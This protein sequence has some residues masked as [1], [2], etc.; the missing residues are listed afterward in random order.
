MH[1]L[2]VLAQL[3]AHTPFDRIEAHHLA[4]TRDF[5]ASH[6]DNFWRRNSADGHITASAF[7]VNSAHSHALMLHHAALDRWLQPGGHID[8]TDQ[9]PLSAAVR[10]T[11]EE[12]KVA[13]T[14]ATVNA[15]ARPL[16]FDVDVHPIPARV[17]QGTAE[18]AHL[19]YDLRYLLVA[20]TDTVV[21]SDESFAFRWV[22]IASLAAGAVDSGIAR[23]ARKI[24]EK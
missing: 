16:L 1:T 21:V 11:L 24:L 7:V 4:L 9:E 14:P 19:H 5:V 8:D 23:M 20:P 17:K 10:E 15:G 6:T 13:A 2:I 22:D 12:T 18:A 3:D